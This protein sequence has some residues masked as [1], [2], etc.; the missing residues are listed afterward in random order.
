MYDILLRLDHSSID[1]QIYQTIENYIFYINMHLKIL[2][3][4]SSRIEL[5][6]TSI[7]GFDFI[8]DIYC[9]TEDD[10]VK[11][12]SSRCLMNILK[13]QLSFKGELAENVALFYYKL[14]L[15]NLEAGYEELF[16]KEK[17]V[18]V[19]NLLDYI[20][21]FISEANNSSNSIFNGIGLVEM[22]KINVKDRVS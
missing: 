19:K 5:T 14:I 3:R 22:I 18:R 16:D 7:I 12:S 4:E 9:N 6:E 17:I 21:S 2:K 10:K 20:V 8:F 1:Q 15:E 11:E 13:T